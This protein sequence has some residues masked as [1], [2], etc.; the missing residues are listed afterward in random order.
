MGRALTR[1]ID[2]WVIA[3]FGKAF[4]DAITV[5]IENVGCAAA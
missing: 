5:R 3:S 1:Q 2:A 4:D